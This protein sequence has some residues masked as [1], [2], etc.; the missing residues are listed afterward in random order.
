[1]DV[2]NTILD[3]DWNLV[4][5]SVDQCLHGGLGLLGR[6]ELHEAPVLEDTVFLGDLWWLQ[7]G[8]VRWHPHTQSLVM[9]CNET[10]IYHVNFTIPVRCCKRSTL[11]DLYCSEGNMLKYLSINIVTAHCQL[12]T[13]LTWQYGGFTMLEKSFLNWARSLKPAGSL[14]TNRTWREVIFILYWCYV[15]IS[16]HHD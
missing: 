6:V 12:L 3:P 10:D 5:L 4:Q 2:W 15:V 7:W 13:L 16:S 11:I 1:M 8:E 9:W 14:S